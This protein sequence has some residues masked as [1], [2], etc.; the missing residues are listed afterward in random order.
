[1]SHTLLSYPYVV[2]N[3]HSSRRLIRVRRVR[4]LRSV[5]GEGVGQQKLEI[6]SFGGQWTP[7]SIGEAFLRLLTNRKEVREKDQF[8]CSFRF[9]VCGRASFRAIFKRGSPALKNYVGNFYSTGSIV[10]YFILIEYSTKCHNCVAGVEW[11][12][13]W[14]NTHNKVCRTE[15]SILHTSMVWYGMVW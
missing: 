8:I 14:T 5:G 3:I 2:K 15:S 1:M 4:E 7:G 11:Y 6:V 12:E 13:Y 10:W 9:C